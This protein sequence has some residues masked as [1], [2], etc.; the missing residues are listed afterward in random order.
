[1]VAAASRRA[2]LCTIYAHR[3]RRSLATSMLAGGP[4]LAVIGQ[5]LRHRWALN[6]VLHAKVDIESLVR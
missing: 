5:V 6:T 2:E 4:S 3:L 1:M